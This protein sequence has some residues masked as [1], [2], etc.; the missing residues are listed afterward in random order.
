MVYIQ[1]E[2]IITLSMTLL[3]DSTAKFEVIWYSTHLQ[4]D[5]VTPIDGNDYGNSGL[6]SHYNIIHATEN[7]QAGTKERR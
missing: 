3:E 7:F 2:L 1:L 6:L 5:P 4:E